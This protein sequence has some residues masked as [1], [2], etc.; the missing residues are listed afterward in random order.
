MRH[1][2]LSPSACRSLLAKKKLPFKRDRR[3]TPGVATAMRVDG[4]LEGVKFLTP[5]W[6]SKFG[7]LDCRLALNLEDVAK[8]LAEHGVARV[9]VGT[10][11]R[12]GSRLPRRHRKLSQHGYALAMDV[13]AFYLNDGTELNVE[14]DYHGE[15]GQPS[16][17]PDAR[18]SEATEASIKLRNLLCDVARA[19]LFHFILT[20]NYDAAHH[21]HFH[22][23]IKRD[24]K[25]SVVR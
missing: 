5:G 11:Y 13:V 9:L 8:V 7:V 19:G 20:P 18:L 16:C 23:D 24:A 21:D 25:R 15:I 6:K 1:A 3:P 14:R 17:G 10:A 4:P 2:N 12:P 22:W